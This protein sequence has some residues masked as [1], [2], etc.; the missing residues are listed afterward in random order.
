M[1]V[2]EFLRRQALGRIADVSYD[3]KIILALSNMARNT[4]GLDAA[5]KVT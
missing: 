1:D 4:K 5:V 2:S 3:N